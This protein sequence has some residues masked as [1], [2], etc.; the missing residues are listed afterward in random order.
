[1]L[2]GLLV[3]IVDGVWE[4]DLPT[5]RTTLE[6]S[7]YPSVFFNCSI[8]SLGRSAR[9]MRF[10]IESASCVGA[11]KSVAGARARTSEMVFAKIIVAVVVLYRRV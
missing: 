2:V 1:V 6:R 11:A 10:A 8:I 9:G 4:E 7:Q 3:L 5:G